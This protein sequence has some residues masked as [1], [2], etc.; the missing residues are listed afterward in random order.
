MILIVV[1][2]HSKWPEV[3]LMTTTSAARTI[4]KLRKLFPTMAYPNSRSVMMEPS[5]Q[6]M[7]PRHSYVR[8]NGI[9]HIKSAPFHPTT[10][11]MAERALRAALTKKKTISRKLTIKYILISF[12]GNYP[13]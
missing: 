7:N 2:P 1:A 10:N 9:K 12:L 8:S 6:Q 11:G 4:E 5:S 3:I 13:G